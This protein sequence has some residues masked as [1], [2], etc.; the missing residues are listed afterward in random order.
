MGENTKA[1]MYHPQSQRILKWC[2]YLESGAQDEQNEHQHQCCS[3]PLKILVLKSAIFAL[4]F[5]F[6]REILHDVYGIR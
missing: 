5:T 2:I 4:D 6:R 1:P 3:S